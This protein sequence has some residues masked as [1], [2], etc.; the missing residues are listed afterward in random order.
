MDSESILSR[1]TLAFG[2]CAR[3]IAS[4]LRTRMQSRPSRSERV[5]NILS[6]AGDHLE[7]I[8]ANI[9]R[10]TAEVNQLG[11]LVAAADTPEYA[12]HRGAARM[13]VCLERLLDDYDEVRRA[14]P[15]HADSEGTRL[16]EKVYRDTLLQIQDWLDETVECLNDPRGALKKRGLVLEEGKRVPIPLDLEFEAPPSMNDLV[17]WTVQRGHTLIDEQRA[18]ARKYR[19]GAGCLGLLATFGLGW[20]LGSAG[21]DGDFDC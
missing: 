8:G 7:Q 16:I 4:R 17:Q 5:T 15:G 19:R 2:Q 10:F 18:S 11:S 13:E 12:V 9:E 1:Q 21:E 14:I 20:W 6:F 3:A